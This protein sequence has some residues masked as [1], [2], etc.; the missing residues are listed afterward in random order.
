MSRLGIVLSSLSP[1]SQSCEQ[2]GED[3]TYN[4]KEKCQERD[5]IDIR[6]LELR[7]QMSNARHT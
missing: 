1:L 5:F 6:H 4:E 3:G 2:V 7:G